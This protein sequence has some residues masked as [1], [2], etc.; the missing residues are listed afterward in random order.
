MPQHGSSPSLVLVG[1]LLILILS[2]CISTAKSTTL[3]TAIPTPTEEAG[4]I[5]GVLVNEEMLP[6]TQANVRLLGT[7]LTA[8]TNDVGAFNFDNVPPGDQTLAVEAPGYAPKKVTLRV[9]PGAVAHTK[10]TLKAVASN[11]PYLLETYEFA[12]FSYY[13]Y[14][15]TN[16]AT[17]ENVAWESY[18]I[19]NIRDQ[20]RFR[21]DRTWTE[22]FLELDW[23]PS[24]PFADQLSLRVGLPVGK[25]GTP[26]TFPIRYNV[27]G[28]SPLPWLFTSDQYNT[29]RRND[30]ALMPYADSEMILGEVRPATSADLPIG[31]SFMQTVNVYGTASYNAPLP[32]DYSRANQGD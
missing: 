24:T 7:N 3:Q 28:P 16:P 10:V 20:F 15:I 1:T 22:L 11:K 29:E 27:D 26:P 2:G 4:V 9:E 14:N 13:A 17:G 8:T 31:F 12:A 32:P 6:I 18:Q 21:F 25:S 5:A 23:T 30:P 19:G